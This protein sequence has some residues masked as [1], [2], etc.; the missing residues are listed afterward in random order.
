[1]NKRWIIFLGTLIFSIVSDQYTKILAVEHIKGKAASIYLNDLFRLVYAE[2]SGAFLGLGSNLPVMWRTAI[3]SVAVSVFLLGF[4][5]F[6]FRKKE[7]S[8]L[9][10]V[11][12]ALVIGGGIGNLIDRIYNG[13]YVVDFMNMGINQIIS[14]IPRTGIFNVADIWIMLGAALL[15]FAPDFKD[16]E[17]ESTS[18]KD[19]KASKS[20]A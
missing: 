1:M 17:K 7:M 19:D 9:G 5:I 15:F 3:F 14:F 8:M 10:N 6:I 2:N 12:S 16:K 4:A 20:K 18:T 11:A 13:G